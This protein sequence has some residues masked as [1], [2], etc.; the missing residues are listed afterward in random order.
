MRYQIKVAGKIFEGSDLRVLL[1]RAVD[2]KRA[3][4]RDETE[5]TELLRHRTD[6]LCASA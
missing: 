6:S 4:I 5:K 1:K 2:A 3:S